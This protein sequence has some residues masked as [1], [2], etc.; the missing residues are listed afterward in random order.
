MLVF[1]KQ[2]RKLKRKNIVISRI[3]VACSDFHGFLSIGSIL[4]ASF[5]GMQYQK[6]Q[7]GGIGKGV[8]A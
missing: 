2:E 7:E 4:H 8:F 6:F 5:S 3:G 1:R